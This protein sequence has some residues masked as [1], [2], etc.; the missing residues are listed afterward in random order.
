[1]KKKKL[2][3]RQAMYYHRLMWGWLAETGSKNKEDHPRYAEFNEKFCIEMYNDCFPCT[4]VGSDSMGSRCY[5]CKIDSPHEDIRITGCFCKKPFHN[6]TY[7]KTPKE[8]RKYATIIRDWKW[9]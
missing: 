3:K 6:W 5:Y 2:T 8:R 1:M 7:A 9:K 4:L